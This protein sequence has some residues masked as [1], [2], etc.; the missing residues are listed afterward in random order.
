MVMV[1][2][3]CK[4]EK[5][6]SISQPSP[7]SNRAPIANVG[8]DVSIALSSCSDKTGFA[9]LDGSGSTDADGDI[10]TFNW[11]KIYGPWSYL[12]QHPTSAKVRVEKL[13]PGEYAFELR[14]RDET[15]LTSK[16]TVLVKVQ[17]SLQ[18]YDLDITFN[19]TYSFTDDYYVGWDYICS[20]PPWYYDLTMIEG[21]G[22]FLPFDQF[23]IIVAECADTTILSDKIH[24]TYFEIYNTYNDGTGIVKESLSGTSSIN[25]KNLRRQGGG[26]ISGAFHVTFGSSQACDANVFNNLS[27]LTVTGSLDLATNTATFKIK[28]KVY[29]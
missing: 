22:T 3:S 24:C 26:S 11:K 19:C 13:L 18:E 16:D 10:L 12:I 4:K 20:S 23:K 9:D 2:V 27:P 28:G 15:G 29:F 14:V 8:A 25:L 21:K 1:F 17:A 7:T 5:D 6:V